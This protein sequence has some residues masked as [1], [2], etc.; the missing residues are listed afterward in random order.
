MRR[1]ILPRWVA[2]PAHWP[3]S[4]EP[5]SSGTRGCWLL[6]QGSL[7]LHSVLLIADMLSAAF[8]SSSR[9]WVSQVFGVIWRNCDPFISSS[10]LGAYSIPFHLRLSTKKR[11][12]RV[13]SWSL[14]VYESILA[15]S[16]QSKWIIWHPYPTC[17]IIT[18]F[19]ILFYFI[20]FKHAW[21]N[22]TSRGGFCSPLCLV[23]VQEQ[24]WSH[25]VRDTT[26]SH[27]TASVRIPLQS[28]T[29][30][31]L[32]GSSTHLLVRLSLSPLGN[33]S[34]YFWKPSGLIPFS[35]NKSSI[36]FF[37]HVLF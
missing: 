13:R 10:F 8:T 29:V 33:C 24:G 2:L 17:F 26:G 21:L 25:V 23:A 5:Q 9:I 19:C 4:R 37:L 27:L 34:E 36:C 32:S 12:N 1:N 6:I 22:G 7:E 28:E 18:V 11:C 15:Y 16:E 14:D 3:R 20:F 35:A 30:F 31:P